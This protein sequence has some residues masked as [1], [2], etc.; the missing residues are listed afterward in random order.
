MTKTTNNSFSVKALV[1][2]YRNFVMENTPKSREFDGQVDFV[3]PYDIADYSSD[4]QLLATLYKDVLGEKANSQVL[5]VMSKYLEH[6]Y[7]G[8]LTNDEY[9]FLRDNFSEFLDY[10]SWFN[11]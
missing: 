9:S 2:K 10:E 1:A 4:Y 5:E 7:K 11:T 8:A 3:I 6:F